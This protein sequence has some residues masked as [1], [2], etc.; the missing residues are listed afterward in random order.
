MTAFGCA[1]QSS[2]GIASAEEAIML[3]KN[4]VISP[5]YHSAP[6]VGELLTWRLGQHISGRGTATLIRVQF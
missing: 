4:G 5:A 2:D 6:A 3:A 1:A